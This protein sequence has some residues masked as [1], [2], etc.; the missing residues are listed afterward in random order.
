MSKKIEDK[1]IAK[2]P[3]KKP[4]EHQKSGL[5][6]LPFGAIS[7]SILSLFP[8]PIF[9]GVKKIV[10]EHKILAIFAIADAFLFEMGTILHDFIE[11]GIET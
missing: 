4:V 6:G 9:R 10:A 8:L 5:R 7:S 1:E 3:S 11:V 2:K